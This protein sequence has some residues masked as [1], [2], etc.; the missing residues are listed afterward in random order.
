M[1]A[2][3]N[4]RGV[5][6][7]TIAEIKKEA[8]KAKEDKKDVGLR[9][10]PFIGVAAA[11]SPVALAATTGYGLYKLFDGLIQLKGRTLEDLI[12]ALFDAPQT[13]E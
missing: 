5:T 13:E 2:V 4:K 12:D 7:K 9:M 10:P 11:I 1:E 3:L 6:V 8:K